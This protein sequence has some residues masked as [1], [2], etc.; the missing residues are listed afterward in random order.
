MK[1]ISNI[2][3]WANALSNSKTQETNL[4]LYQLV[5]QVLKAMHLTVK[6]E[7]VLREHLLS[8]RGED[9]CVHSYDN[10]DHKHRFYH[11]DVDRFSQPEHFESTTTSVAA[12]SSRHFLDDNAL[13]RAQSVERKEK[14]CPK[15]CA[16]SLATR[17]RCR[18][19]L[20]ECSVALK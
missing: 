12:A 20:N 19:L 18:S 7:F 6:D 13:T 15:C 9:D 3:E 17:K 10:V 2:Y 14:T 5:C 16:P 4:I 1:E 11:D 8:F